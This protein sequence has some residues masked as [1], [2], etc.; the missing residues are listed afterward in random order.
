MVSTA[1]VQKSLFFSQVEIQTNSRK[2]MK[3]KKDI[4]TWNFAKPDLDIPARIIYTIY[5][6]SGMD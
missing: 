4:P 5:T 2:K 1:L 3:K 6:G